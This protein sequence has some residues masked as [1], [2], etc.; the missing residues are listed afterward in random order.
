[1]DDK[2][3]GKTYPVDAGL[4]FAAEQHQTPCHF[5]PLVLR[6][7]APRE[8]RDKVDDATQRER[9]AAVARLRKVEKEQG[10]GAYVD[11]V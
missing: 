10:P 4:L 1:V 9:E 8:K 11:D 6:Y 5:A 2:E 3:P 7:L